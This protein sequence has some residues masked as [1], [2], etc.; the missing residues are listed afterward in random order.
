MGILDEIIVYK[1]FE[2]SR[3]RARQPVGAL[4]AECRGLP[5][6]RDFE[7]ALRPRGG[8]RVSLIAEVKRASPSQ[9]ALRLDLDPV[10][11]ARAYASAGA[12]AVSV[13]TDEKYF[14]GSVDDLV[15]VR[16]AV[17]A[18]LLR[19]EFIVEEYQLWE[20]RAAGADAVLLIV[21][22]LDQQQLSDLAQ[23][24]RGIGLA[25][26]VEV[27]TA[28]ELERAVALGARVIGVN[29]RDLQSLQTSLA[30]S[31]GL[32]PLVPAGPVAVS[33]SGINTSADVE[34]V[35]KAGAHAI[36]VGEALVRAPDVEGKVRELLLE[37]AG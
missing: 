14:R 2:V 10:S 7:A 31:L 11:Q 37:R 26:L 32:L 16:E 13:L 21:A 1:K 33:E 15:A 30:P 19:K 5:P 29:N 36:L 35:V 6:A 4:E 22:A 28:G 25:T 9:G 17:G 20:S 3:L 34:R 18:P 24:A 23:A 12:S 8:R 27:H